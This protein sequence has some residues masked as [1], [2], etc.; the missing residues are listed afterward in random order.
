MP[1]AELLI[2][3]ISALI[4]AIL[5]S[6]VTGYIALRKLST[7][8]KALEAQIAATKAET[9]ATEAETAATLVKGVYG[10]IL[11]DLRTRIEEQRARID[12]LQSQ[13]DIAQ[14]QSQE[15]REKLLRVQL[16]LEQAFERIGRVRSR[17]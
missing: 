5:A 1:L 10:E 2:P 14:K 9:T 8:K 3:A 11:D 7:E 4:A 15:D 6:G 17:K 13:V 16:Q 12:D